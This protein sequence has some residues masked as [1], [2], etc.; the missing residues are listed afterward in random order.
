HLTTAGTT[1]VWNSTSYSSL[2]SFQAATGQESHGLEGDPKWTSPATGD[3]RLT[4]GSPAIDSA[5][6]GVPGQPS[7]DAD[8]N[9]RIDDPATAN[10]GAGPRTFDDRG[11]YEYGT[12]VG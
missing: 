12:A 1:L 4:S 10:T 7:A 5:N 2:A 6:S 3:F 8:G 11:A 9:G